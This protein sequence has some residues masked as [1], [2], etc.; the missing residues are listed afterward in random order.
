MNKKISIAAA[1]A[2]ALGVMSFAHAPR[3]A[4]S[5]C[6]DYVYAYGGTGRCVKDIQ[7]I[8]NGVTTMKFNSVQCG[9]KL[10]NTFLT[11]DGVWGTKTDQKVRNFQGW[12][13]LSADGVV[14]RNTWRRLC[15]EAW[16]LRNWNPAGA[17]WGHAA[18]HDAGCY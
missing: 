16:D 15:S 12:S 3:A 10:T 13:C 7:K 4:A 1:F 17:I 8:I 11:T 14:G 5:N 6:V 2:M 18:G 9:T